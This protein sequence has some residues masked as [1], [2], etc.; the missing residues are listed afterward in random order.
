MGKLEPGILSYPGAQCAS[1]QVAGL[2]ELPQGYPCVLWVQIESIFVRHGPAFRCGQSAAAP[3]QCYC[4][5]LPL[6]VAGSETIFDGSTRAATAGALIAVPNF[7]T[8]KT[9]DDEDQR[10]SVHLQPVPDS[11]VGTRECCG[12]GG[13]AVRRMGSPDCG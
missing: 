6:V 10:N 2:L 13:A 5:H 8:Q 7:H 1:A 11:E 3:R 9:R 12:T 4:P